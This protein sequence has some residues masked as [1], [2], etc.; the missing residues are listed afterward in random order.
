MP[1]FGL[2]D[3]PEDWEI[4]LDQE[5]VDYLDQV[6]RPWK[7]KDVARPWK[8]TFCR[9]GETQRKYVKDYKQYL[10]EVGLFERLW[11]RHRYKDY[12]F[13]EGDPKRYIDTGNWIRK[14]HLAVIRK[15]GFSNEELERRIIGFRVGPSSQRIHRELHF[16]HLPI[17]PNKWWAW[18]LGLYFSSGTVYLR[19]R[20]YKHKGIFFRVRVHVPVIQMVKEAVANI[21]ST[22]LVYQ[23]K[24]KSRAKKDRGLGTTFRSYVTLGWPVFIVLAK[25]GLPTEFIDREASGSGSRSYKT[26]VPAW[27]KN[28]D[29][30][31]QFF[32]EALTNG[33]GR[34]MLWPTK[35]DGKPK[36]CVVINMV[37]KPEQYVKQF[38][39]DVNS[40]FSR[41]GNSGYLRKTSYYN[42]DDPDMVCYELYFYRINIPEFFLEHFRITK[43]DLRARLIISKEAK[44]DPVLYEALRTLRSPDNVILGMLIE[45]PLSKEDMVSVLQMRE[46]GIEESIEKLMNLGLVFYDEGLYYFEPEPFRQ[47]RSI[48]HN[49]VGKVREITTEETVFLQRERR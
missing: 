10:L 13:R 3:I 46:E 29:E 28:N 5:F 37:G 44:K 9:A 15:L 21:G 30:F 12:H 11:G 25:M 41:H 48:E 45:K 4:E 32:I 2:V 35:E 34:S 47:K 26:R 17:R 27:I 31:M 49:M 33:R 6:N 36:L 14:N 7:Y 39:V 42:N 18:L 19:E 43:P 23:P 40:W 1:T 22:V 38:L 16:E 8:G 24:G 20:Y